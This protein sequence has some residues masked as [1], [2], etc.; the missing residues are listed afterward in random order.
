REAR[1]AGGRRGKERAASLRAEQRLA[2]GGRRLPRPG[3][4]VPRPGLVTYYTNVSRER[5][6]IA[7]DPLAEGVKPLT[8]NAS[9]TPDAAVADRLGERG[10]RIRANQRQRDAAG[11][12]RGPERSL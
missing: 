12:H 9:R 3:R 8:K 7:S 10:A 1:N 11:R 2:A 4:V 6:G 5:T